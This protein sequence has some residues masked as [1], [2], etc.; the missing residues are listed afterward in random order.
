MEVL[1]V[2]DKFRKNKSLGEQLIP[3]SRKYAAQPV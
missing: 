3:R 1:L 2:F